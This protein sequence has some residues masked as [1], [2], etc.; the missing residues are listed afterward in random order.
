[1]SHDR[2][3]EAGDGSSE[4]I[5]GQLTVPCIPLGVGSEGGGRRP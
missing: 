5:A 2:Y 4:R 3:G 1:M